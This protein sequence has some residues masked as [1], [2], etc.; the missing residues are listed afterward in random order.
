MLEENSPSLD[1]SPDARCRRWRIGL[2]SPS[3]TKRKGKFPL[4]WRRSHNYPLG[5]WSLLLNILRQVEEEGGKNALRQQTEVERTFSG[6]GERRGNSVLPLFKVCGLLGTSWGGGECPS[7]DAGTRKKVS[8]KTHPSLC[9]FVPP[10]T[11]LP[12]QTASLCPATGLLTHSINITVY[13]LWYGTAQW[14]S[15]LC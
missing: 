9:Q 8:T 10:S 5:C 14:A 12:T 3:L 2:C 1:T 13:L 7:P 11:H 4:H 6:K 15:S